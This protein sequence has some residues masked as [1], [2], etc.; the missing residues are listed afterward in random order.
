MLPIPIFNNF[1]FGLRLQLHVKEHQYIYTFSTKYLKTVQRLAFLGSPSF[2][3][4]LKPK[5]FSQI[6]ILLFRLTQIV[7]K[8]SFIK[9]LNLTLLNLAI[10]RRL[11]QTKLD[12][13]ILNLNI[14]NLNL[15]F[16]VIKMQSSKV[17]FPSIFQEIYIKCSSKKN[18][19]K[20]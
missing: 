11:F 16:Y 13:I 8:I 10:L 7:Q 19:Q 18:I 3:V 9:C 12:H 14:L 4:L 17:L 6:Y 2:Q 5:H 15:L 1:L 20:P